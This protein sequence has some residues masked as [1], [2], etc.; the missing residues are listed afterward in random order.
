MQKP[1]K[2]ARGEHPH[3]L[4]FPLR[5]LAGALLCLLLLPL[6]LVAALH[7]PAVQDTILRAA[8]QKLESSA[9]LQIQLAG[10]RWSPFRELSL[11]DLKVKAAGEN[12][13][14]CEK[15]NL[16]YHL[17]WKWP[18][19][20]PE[21]I[22][23]EKPSLHLER[24]AQGRWQLPAR[25]GAPPEASQPGKPFPWSSFPWPQVRIV[26]GTITAAQNG[27]M[28]LFIRDV[29][30]TLSVQEM[31]DSDGPWL[32]LDFGQWHGSAEV[33]AW[34]R[35]QFSGQAEIRNQT[36]VVPE[37]SWRFRASAASQPGPVDA[38]SPL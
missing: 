17:S 31:M 21:A 29:N 6:A 10:A 33:P 13:I 3:N 14:E 36:L 15:A 1:K 27:Q 23:L 34:G 25:K 35:W 24:D 7:V 38:R 20:Y 2:T 28:V 12:L 8:V 19:L 11:L 26:S 5:C 16:G 9:D 18:Y 4:S 22:V 37:L 30:A 32:K